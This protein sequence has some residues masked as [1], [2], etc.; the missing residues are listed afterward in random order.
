LLLRLIFRRL[1]VLLIFSRVHKPLK[2]LRNFLKSLVVRASVIQGRVGGILSSLPER[3]LL[4][5]PSLIV[6][7]RQQCLANR[8]GR[9]RLRRILS[10]K[11]R[12]SGILS[13]FR[14][15]ITRRGLFIG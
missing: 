11:S 15:T 10:D 9:S 12:L 13:R 14:F 6:R 4:Q 5:L 1:S 8:L 3:G 7:W 2:T